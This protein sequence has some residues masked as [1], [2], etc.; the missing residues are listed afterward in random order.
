MSV[1][2]SIPRLFL[3]L[4]LAFSL[5]FSACSYVP[6]MGDDKEDDLAFE[7]DS[8]SDED[9]AD[10]AFKDDDKDKDQDTDDFFDGD[11]KSTAKDF[12]E[13]FATVESKTDRGEMKG[14]VESLQA[15]QEAL[16][17][18]VR[19]LEEII[20]TMEPKV[21]ATKEALDSRDGGGSSN[22]EPD[23]NELKAQV[24]MLNEEISRMKAS[25]AA[26]SSRSSSV[27][28]VRPSSSGTPPEYQRAL[29]AYQRGKY[30]ESILLFQDFAGKNPPSNLIDNIHFWMGNNYVKL[31]MYDEAIKQFETVISDYSRGNKVHDS[32]YM[33]GV[34]YHKKG[35][36][37]RALDILETALK[38]NPPSETR[39][40]IE[41]QLLAIQ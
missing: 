25:S 32:R 37:G 18:K 27:T 1:E 5:V 22:L 31:E 39:N 13:D 38:Y 20:Q 2:K 36:K 6:W 7:D 19:E 40:K 26:G 29:A 17:S 3:V 16:T 14:D 21:E 41:K 35:D 30:D 34:T 4:L 24:A 33:L 28:R 23:V 10:N 11:G 12:E 15:K 9:F 8:A